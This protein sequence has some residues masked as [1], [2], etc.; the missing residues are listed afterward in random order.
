MK[1]YFSM[2]M[3]FLVIKKIYKKILQIPIYEKS[4][5]STVIVSQRSARAIKLEGG[6]KRPPPQPL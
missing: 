3:Y 4:K 1:L 6:A 5:N 2:S